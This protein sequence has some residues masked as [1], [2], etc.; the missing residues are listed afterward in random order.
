MR[1]ALV[2]GRKVAP[3]RR[4]QRGTCPGCGAE[5]SARAFQSP[6]KVAHWAHLRRTDCDPWWENESEWHLGWKAAI[7]GGD[8]AREEVIVRD[9]VRRWHQADVLAR[10]GGVV[11]LQRSSL[12]ADAVNQREMFYL[13]NQGRLIWI[14]DYTARAN[15]GRDARVDAAKCWRLLD[16]GAEVVALVPDRRAVL[17]RWPREELVRLLRDEGVSAVEAICEEQRGRLTGPA[18]PLCEE[19]S[20]SDERLAL[21]VA[22]EAILHRSVSLWEKARI[23]DPA[24]SSCPPWLA[25]QAAAGPDPSMIQS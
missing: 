15:W 13:R 22:K 19:E 5:V 25:A 20:I 4:G 16:H 18:T 3:E 1:Y 21:L 10:D 11:E 14:F 23:C 2:Q 7:S 24:L 17:V 9:G 8:S 6:H 12:T